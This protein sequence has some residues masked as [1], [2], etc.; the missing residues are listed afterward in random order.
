VQHPYAQ[1]FLL[2]E[3]S[4]WNLSAPPQREVPGTGWGDYT[5]EGID[6]AP[7]QKFTD[8][9][10]LMYSNE[11]A[12]EWYKAHIKTV[13]SRRNTVNGHLYTEDP[14]IMTWQLANEP[15]AAG[16]ASVLNP[17]D[18]LFPWVER[19]SNYIRTMAPKQLINVGFESK[20]GE[21]YFKQVHNFP[22]VD[23]TTTHCWVQNWGVY[24]MV[25]IYASGSLQGIH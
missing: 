22:N 24:D 3:Q 4:S 16:A 25:S 7:Y 21:Y 5:K 8:F 9:A 6:A 13:M 15:Q 20:Q 2:I 11:Q 14:T 1:F 19:I 12:E 17:K 10:N 18:Q 23:Y